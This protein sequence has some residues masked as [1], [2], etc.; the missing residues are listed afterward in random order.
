MGRRFALRHAHRRFANTRLDRIG[1]DDLARMVTELRAEGLSEWTI[2]GVLQAV[3]Q[4]YRYA[5]R[6][7]GWSGQNPVTAMDKSERAKVTSSPRRVV[8]TADQIRE[9]IAAASEPWRTLFTVTALT[10]ARQ[11]E[12]L[13]LRWADLRLD[14]LDDAEVV[15]RAQLSRAGERVDVKSDDSAREVP[16]TRA[17]AERLAGFQL[18][19]QLAG[20]DTKATAY[21]FATRSGRPISQRNASRALRNAQEKAKCPDGR[22]TFPI[23]HES[24]AG[25][26]GK[27]V[28]V[29]VPRGYLPSTHSFRHAFASL[30]LA[31]GESADEVA[32]L[33]GHK[34]ARVTRAVYLHDVRDAERRANRRARIGDRLGS[35]LNASPPSTA[36][37]ATA[38]A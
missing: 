4:T 22:W 30:A 35:V 26:G 8:F 20:H 1:P 27:P 21:V 12:V 11:S 18:S 28:P 36:T 24:Q 10:G 2:S 5:T 25:P 6:R 31:D 9:T 34:D 14:D 3:N 16:I 29:P 13:G 38:E 37:V 32:F 19:R 7:L 15:Y 17:L 33:L 23:L